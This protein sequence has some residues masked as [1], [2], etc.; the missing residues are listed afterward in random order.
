MKYLFSFLAAFALFFVFT[1]SHA[2]SPILH[3]PRIHVKEGESTNWAGYAALTSLTN[4]S[5]GSVS[6]VQGKWLVP[7]MS[8]TSTGNT[9]SSIWVGIDGYSN[10]TVEQTG[11]EADCTSGQPQYYGWYEMYPKFG[12]K[13]PVTI[14]QG[15]T[16][17]GKVEYIGS[18]N[19]RLT[20]TNAST[21]KSFVTT[22]RN[23]RAQRTSAEWIVEA[24]SSGGVL[25]LANFWTDFLSGSQA[26]IKGNTSTINAFANDRIDMVN[27]NG[28][29]TKATTSALTNGTDFTVTWN[30]E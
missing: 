8:C 6:N 25:P 9:Y 22:Q 1:Q 5:V 14:S 29:V 13:V 30:H 11:I 26:R 18:G 16:I 17:T 27:S 23:S 2:N 19:F 7:T 12:Y 24:P 15:N 21:G 20:L 3:A 10:G 28:T 4:P